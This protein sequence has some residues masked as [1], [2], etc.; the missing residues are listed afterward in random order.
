METKYPLTHYIYRRF[1]LPIA[2]FLAGT[3]VSP[4]AITILATLLGFLS[5]CLIAIEKALP[6]VLVLLI[7]Q[8]FD[9][10]DGDLARLSGRESSR[11]AY[12]DRVLDRFVDAALI[13]A[14]IALKPSAFWLVGALA[15]TGSLLVSLSRAM[16]EAEGAECRVGIA[17][18]DFRIIA[19]AVGVLAG[20]IYYLLGFLALL[21]FLTTFHRM[22][23]SMKQM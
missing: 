16:A 1:S 7:S 17:S 18:R 22:Y 21:G 2:E 3:G 15:L 20:Q 13:I 4:H 14:L 12:L 8:I 11:G 6:G 5:A 9:C 10:V 23:Y 19:I